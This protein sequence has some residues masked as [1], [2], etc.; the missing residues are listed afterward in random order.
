[1]FAENPFNKDNRPEN[2]RKL[3]N[4]SHV[5][6]PFQASLAFGIETSH[7][8]CTANQMVAF[9]TH[10]RPMFHLRVNQFAGFY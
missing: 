2:S 1:M 7:L 4:F 9:L 8:V 3:V 10:F 5:F 6:N